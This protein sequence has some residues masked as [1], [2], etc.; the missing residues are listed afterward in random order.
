VAASAALPE[1]RQCGRTRGQK[2]SPSIFPLRTEG[3]VFFVHAWPVPISP[4][5]LLARL[6]ADEYRRLLPDLQTV[7]IRAKRV[8]LKSH[9][10]VRQ[11]YFLAGGLCSITHVMADGQTAGVAMVGN[12][13]VVG[14]AACGA[15]PDSGQMAVVEIAAG[16]AQAMDV[17]A[18]RREMERQT[19]F[20]DLVHRYAQAFVEGL[21]QSVACNA[22]HPIEKRC[23]RTLLEIRDR[24]GGREFPMTQDVLATL[25][26]VRRASVTLAVGTLHR[27][28]VVEHAHKNIVIVDAAGLEHAACECYALIKAHF[29]RL[30]S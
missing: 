8:L 26:G 1:N 21:M 28:G 4:N 2:G 12:E 20:S 7:R 27:T 14:M 17:T 23:A 16:D 13:G 22:L 25:L 6:S 19:E 29:T 3:L 10:P 15:D 5:R 30:L 9:V 24:I 11:I 18:F